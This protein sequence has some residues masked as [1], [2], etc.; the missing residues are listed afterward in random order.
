MAFYRLVSFR[1]IV[2]L[3]NQKQ[4]ITTKE[5]HPPYKSGEV[6]CLFESDNP[7]QIFMK[8]GE[9]LSELRNIPKGEYIYLLKININEN[10]EV[11]KSQNGWPES[12]VH[13]G[14]INLDKVELIGRA[15]ICSNNSSYYKL[16]NLE[17]FS[18]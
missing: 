16:D 8:Y 15:R 12:K 18:Q 4:L 11:D 17:Y 1:E 5:E 3:I 7:N 10:I 14:Q 9:T 2:E 6:V 13:L